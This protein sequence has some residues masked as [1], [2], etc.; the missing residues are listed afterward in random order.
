VVHASGRVRA[1]VDQVAEKDE[2]IVRRIAR[3][4]IEQVEELRAPAMYVTNDKRTHAVCSP[5]ATL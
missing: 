1:A 2:R 5:A 3:Q 4:H